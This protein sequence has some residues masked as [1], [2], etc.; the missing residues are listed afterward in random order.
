MALSSRSA[1]LTTEQRKSA[2]VLSRALR[3]VQQVFGRSEGNAA[4]PIEVGKQVIVEE[5]SVR[6]DYLE[7]VDPEA[8]EPVDLLFSARLWQL[9]ALWTHPN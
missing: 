4:K 5:S 6:L 3:P 8:L 1:Y 9:R 7:I 2:L